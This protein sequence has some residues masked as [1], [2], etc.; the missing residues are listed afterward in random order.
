MV[1]ELVKT[2]QQGFSLAPRSFDEA[3]E[4]AK[5]MASSDMVPK[6]YRGKPANVMVAVQMGA[7]LNLSPTQALQNIAVINGRPC[8]WGDAVLAVVRSHRDCL[9][10]AETMSEDGQEAIC[11]IKRRGQS[12]T[13][14][15]FSVD[16]AKRAGLWGKQGPWSQY[17]Q[18][19]LQMRARSFACRDAFPDALRGISA[20]EE[21]RDV[22]DA[23]TGQQ[24]EAPPRYVDAQVVEVTDEVVD[25]LLQDIMGAETG[26]ELRALRERILALP[27]GSDARKAA[28][29]AGASRA[30]ELG[31]AKG[32]SEAQYMSRAAAI[33]DRLKGGCDA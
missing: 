25:G 3:M 28:V 11:R 4:F 9:D 21:I 23:R 16:D 24:T 26:D 7:D 2:G 20:A 31:V 29:E 19:M 12:D 13:V 15:T 33:A 17:P 1:S 14:R 27:H 8:L 5:V 18:R 6:D 32:G 30:A 22:V 10:V